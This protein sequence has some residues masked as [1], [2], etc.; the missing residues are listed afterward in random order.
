MPSLVPCCKI[1]A[2]V[3]LNG[4]ASTIKYPLLC[5][6]EPNLA[7]LQKQILHFYNILKIPLFISAFF[8]VGNLQSGSLAINEINATCH[9]GCSCNTDV[10]DPVCG[11]DDV[12]Y[13]SA[14]LAGCTTYA[15]ST[16]RWQLACEFH[17]QQITR[18]VKVTICMLYIKVL[19]ILLSKNILS[20]D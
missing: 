4:G 1:F 20:D 17:V 7:S 8:G 13:Y 16:V 10:F 14:C 6:L 15:N 2:G 9:E 12:S 11:S 3:K 5:L 19:L 18:D